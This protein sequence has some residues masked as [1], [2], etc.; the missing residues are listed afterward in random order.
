MKNKKINILFLD[1]TPFIGGAQLSLISHIKEISRDNFNI[2]IGC[3][4]NARNIGLTD[5]YKKLNVKYHF[6]SFGH[7]KSFSPAVFFR[8]FKSV[9][10][11]R[12]IARKENID[13]VFGNTVRAN[14][15]GSLAILFSGVKIVWFMHDDT[16]PKF[17]FNALRFIPER[18][19]YVSNS[20]ACHHSVLTN[21]KNIVVYNGSD[22][23]KKVKGI[24]AEQ[25]KQK[26]ESWGANEDTAVIGYV[27]RLV[28]EKGPQILI[29][30]VRDLLKHGMTN[31]KC[32][33]VG[34]GDGQI[35]NNEQCL[36]EI[37]R[38][39]ELKNYIIFAGQ[40][41]NVPLAMASLDIFCL[42]S[43]K[44]EGFGLTIIEAMMAKISV[45]AT[46]IGGPAEII[47]HMKTGL[48]VQPNNPAEL[49]NAIKKLI[50]DKKLRNEIINNAYDYV[51]KYYTAE[52]ITK[53][54]EIIY[55]K[56]I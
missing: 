17:L 34:S 29:K 4:K 44:S 24:S 26:R 9:L 19:L 47:Q 14:I 10:E 53:K 48:L 50:A 37:A 52:H 12:R 51:I 28:E 30:A 25:I 31:I 21:F 32:V 35:N 45:I 38:D 11:I 56:L 16:F 13:L 33:I 40:E 23:Y 3:S 46:N 15:A 22:F 41:K 7:L 2:I 49:S 55:K 43:I 54:L 1:H 39:K 36:K 18:I 27:G 42:T 5:C 8:L 6:V 20:V